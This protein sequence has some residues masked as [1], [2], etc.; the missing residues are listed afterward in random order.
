MTLGRGI[1]LQEG[2]KAARGGEDYV[3]GAS[4]KMSSHTTILKR[5]IF[6]GIYLLPSGI[7]DDTLFK[8]F[9]VA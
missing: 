2:G 7:K 9:Y 6:C 4:A 3:M 5:I 8:P 1:G